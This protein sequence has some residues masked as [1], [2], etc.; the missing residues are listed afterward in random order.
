M[1]PQ[2]LDRGSSPGHARFRGLGGGVKRAFDTSGDGALHASARRHR[3]GFPRELD[4]AEREP[5]FDRSAIGTD[6]HFERLAGVVMHEAEECVI[7]AVRSGTIVAIARSSPPNTST[8]NGSQALRL[9]TPRSCGLSMSRPGNRS[10]DHSRKF[11]RR[12]SSPPPAKPAFRLGRPTRTLRSAR[13][14]AR[15]LRESSVGAAAPGRRRS[16]RFPLE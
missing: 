14:S 5:A 3:C 1:S 8:E 12:L 13:R 9:R 10:R 15:R 6:S 16:W 11:A 4:T 7:D 2:A